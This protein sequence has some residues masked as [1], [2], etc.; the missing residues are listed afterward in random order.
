VSA[1]PGRH[2]GMWC[3][4]L[5]LECCHNEDDDEGDRFRVRGTMGSSGRAY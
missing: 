3:G 1:V 2:L 4:C 5:L